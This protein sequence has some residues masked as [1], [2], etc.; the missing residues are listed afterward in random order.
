MLEAM[1]AAKD[2]VPNGLG[3]VEAIFKTRN[4][5]TS[6]HIQM[7]LSRVDQLQ[8][9]TELLSSVYN[10]VHAL[11][12][13]SAYRVLGAFLVLTK[14]PFTYWLWGICPRPQRALARGQQRPAHGLSTLD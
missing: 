13:F 5:K 11:G 2:A 9:G 12:L 3:D 4:G 7:S 10:V 8:G 14:T 1:R 6:G